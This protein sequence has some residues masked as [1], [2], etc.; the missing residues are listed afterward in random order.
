M[1]KSTNCHCKVSYCAK[2]SCA[3]FIQTIHACDDSNNRVQNRDCAH[4]AIQKITKY[5]KQQIQCKG[6]FVH[7]LM[8]GVSLIPELYSRKTLL[9]FSQF[10]FISRTEL[11]YENSNRCRYIDLQQ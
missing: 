10:Q 9:T 1:D 6:I 2:Y 11:K 7:N 4:R 3:Y 8:F 5:S